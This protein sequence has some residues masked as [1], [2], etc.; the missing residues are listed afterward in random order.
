MLR[1][2]FGRLHLPGAAI[3]RWLDSHVQLRLSILLTYLFGKSMYF[4]Q[5]LR[6]AAGMLR[7]LRII[8]QPALVLLGATAGSAHPL[9]QDLH[10]S[11]LCSS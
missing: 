8:A 11:G 9:C 4:A 7:Y 5:L 6:W 2:A 10:D 3:L 1:S